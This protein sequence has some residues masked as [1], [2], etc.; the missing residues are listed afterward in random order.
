MADLLLLVSTLRSYRE[1]GYSAEDGGGSI[2]LMFSR[3]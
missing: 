3:S 2:V 1:A